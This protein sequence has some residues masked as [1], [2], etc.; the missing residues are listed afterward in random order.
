[1]CVHFV[2][3]QNNSVLYAHT[4]TIHSHSSYAHATVRLK[5]FN[6][7]KRRNVVSSSSSSLW[8][9]TRRVEAEKGAKKNTKIVKTNCQTHRERARLSTVFLFLRV[10]ASAAFALHL[11]CQNRTNSFYNVI[12]YAQTK[13]PRRRRL[14]D[15]R[16]ME[17]LKP[18]QKTKTQ[19]RKKAFKSF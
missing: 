10:R 4:T 13:R 9:P 8:S 1:M 18:G 5:R 12:I 11:L 16:L 15:T 7:Y 17:T 6:M 2:H 14:N 19:K 3:A